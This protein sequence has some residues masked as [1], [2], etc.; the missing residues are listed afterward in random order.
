[1]VLVVY[2]TNSFFGSKHTNETKKVNSREKDL[3]KTCKIGISLINLERTENITNIL[4]NFEE[5]DSEINADHKA[6]GPKE[7]N[8][9][10]VDTNQEKRKSCFTKIPLI[11]KID[12]IAFA[13]FNISYLI[14][15]LIYWL[16]IKDL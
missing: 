1:M 15:N 6:Y 14:A 3:K 4:T 16:N 5:N 12:I 10:N 13:I 11:T 8:S 7:V 2:Q 9:K